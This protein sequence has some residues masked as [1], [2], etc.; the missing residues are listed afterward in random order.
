VAKQFTYH[1]ISLITGIKTNV[2]VFIFLGVIDNLALVYDWTKF[3][4]NVFNCFLL[5][6]A[7]KF[8]RA[9]I[10]NFCF[11]YRTLT[12]PYHTVYNRTIE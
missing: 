7:N 5:E 11:H 6:A 4:I 9:L 12:R 8:L 2:L 3:S 1:L 10:F